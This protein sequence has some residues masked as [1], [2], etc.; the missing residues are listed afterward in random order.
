MEGKVFAVQCI[1]YL[2]VGFCLER[3][4]LFSHSVHPVSR[5]GCCGCLQPVLPWAIGFIVQPGRI[6]ILGF[7]MAVICLLNG[8]LWRCYLPTAPNNAS[9]HDPQS[10]RRRQLLFRK[11]FHIL[12]VVL[13]TPVS[14]IT[15]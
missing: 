7:W 15:N 3:Q 14:Q 5:S 4:A 8:Y 6:L 12:A 10:E 11:A 13:F 2:C 9:G 1:I